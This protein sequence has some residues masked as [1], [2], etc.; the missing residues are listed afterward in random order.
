MAE[1]F[2]FDVVIGNPPYQEEAK[3]T[4]DNPIY[5]L[6]MDEAFKIAERVSF[7]TP[8]RFLFN[9]GKTPKSWNQKMLED[10]H[11]KVVYYEKDAGRV[12][13]NNIFE[14][15]VAITYRDASVVFGAIG[16]YTNY[17]ELNS[18]IQ[19]IAQKD[20]E[21]LTTIIYLQC[22]FNLAELYKT[23]PEY[24]NL[25]GSEGKEKRLTT[26]I[27]ES[28]GDLF[29]DVKRAEDDLMILGLSNS[30][31]I[32]LYIP[33]RFIEPTVNL[34]KYKVLISKS[35]GA[36]GT[37][38]DEP[39]RIISTPEIGV[40]AQGFTQSFI[41]IGS[42]DSFNTADAAFKY[43]KS[44]FARAMLGVLKVT[45]DNPPEKWKYVPLQDF[46]SASDIIWS[47]SIREIDQQLYK[48]YGLDANEID[49]IESHIKEME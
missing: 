22:K 9:A 28:L 8:A 41:S 48:K 40:S 39:A 10:E 24:S 42:F 1:K 30:K 23:H 49:F 33:R 17:L 27:F 44:K 46:T 32:S 31:R 45:Q 18:I 25:I 12:F 2:K 43:V 34:D 16:Q 47:K 35:N 38:G 14:G 4:S 13:K 37:L 26:S 29:T 21:S 6:F 36:S 3:D 15:G 5:H 19:K 7:I 20:E 11:L